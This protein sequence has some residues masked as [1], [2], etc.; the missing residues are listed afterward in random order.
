MGKRIV[1]EREGR[2]RVG[3]EEGTGLVGLN[4]EQLLTEGAGTLTQDL[5]RG[6]G[7]D[8][9]EGEYEGVDVGE[10]QVHRGHGIRHRVGR[11]RL[12]LVGRELHHVLGV[13]FHRVVAQLRLGNGLAIQATIHSASGLQLQDPP[14]FWDRSPVWCSCGAL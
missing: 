8:G 1:S 13:H 6:H 12:R 4:H 9:G 7:N 10:V 11:H 3:R 14:S 2:K 5:V